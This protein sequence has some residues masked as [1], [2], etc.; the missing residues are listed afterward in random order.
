ML[1]S[2]SAKCTNVSIHSQL[3]IITRL[4]TICL[5]RILCYFCHISR[6]SNNS[7]ERFILVGNVEGKSHVPIS[8]QVVRPTKGN[9]RSHPLRSS[10]RDCR[11]NTVGGNHT[12]Q[13]YLLWWGTD[14]RERRLEFNPLLKIRA[15]QLLDQ[16]SNSDSTKCFVKYFSWY[17]KQTEA[18]IRVCHIGQSDGQRALTL[19]LPRFVH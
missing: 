3:K 18:I 6:R 7:I 13:D 14:R 9:W 8:N 19:R 11:Q 17:C 10:P 12:Q 5:Q 1:Q 16:L 4:S 2:V 15:S